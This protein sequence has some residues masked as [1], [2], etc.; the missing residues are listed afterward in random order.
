MHMK[1]DFLVLVAISILV[2]VFLERPVTS[3]KSAFAS[4][5]KGMVEFSLYRS[6]NG[7]FQFSYPRHWNLKEMNSQ[8]EDILERFRLDYMGEN[9]QYQGVYTLFTSSEWSRRQSQL[10][11]LPGQ[12]RIRSIHGV[13][14]QVSMSRTGNTETDYYVAQNGDQI[15]FIESTATI[16]DNA[17]PERQYLHD[18]IESYRF[19][20]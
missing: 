20:H 8:E 3:A 10:S 13:E 5:P 11:C 15:L 9:F 4:E 6:Q 19:F 2:M 18:T 14:Y 12:C 7:Q 1:K 17:T 16:S